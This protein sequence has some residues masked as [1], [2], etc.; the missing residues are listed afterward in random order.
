I[1]FL[2]LPGFVVSLYGIS[3]DESGLLMA[4]LLG[5]ADTASGMLLL[6]LRDIARSQA[7]RLISLKGA[8][9]WS[10][11][12]VILLLNTLSGLLN[13]LGWVSVVLFIGIV[14]LFARDAS[15]R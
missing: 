13:F 9:E 10:L 12:A 4:R 14:V 11:I 1:G 3:L 6:G 5:A 8:V 7:S 2:L 15:G